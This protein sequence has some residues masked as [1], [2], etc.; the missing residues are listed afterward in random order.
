[1]NPRSN[2][3]DWW[4]AGA[5]RPGSN[6]HCW[7]GRC[8]PRWCSSRWCIGRRIL[9]GLQGS[10]PVAPLL[11]CLWRSRP[12]CVGCPRRSPWRPPW[13]WWSSAAGAPRRARR[14]R[15]EGSAAGRRWRRR[16][17]WWTC[18]GTGKRRVVQSSARCICTS[19]RG[20]CGSVGRCRCHPTTDA[21]CGNYGSLRPSF[22]C[23]Y[24]SKSTRGRTIPLRLALGKSSVA[25]RI[26]SICQLDAVPRLYSQALCNR[27]PLA[28]LPGASHQ[29]I[30]I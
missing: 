19:S 28:S 20:C 22:L 12:G 8:R 11:C 17:R 25:T 14:P 18:A 26:R 29:F 2:T 1:M 10:F 7:C 4:I 24:P 5:G 21:R 13:A 6:R 9:P 16:K 15:A 3:F 27:C 30:L 23:T